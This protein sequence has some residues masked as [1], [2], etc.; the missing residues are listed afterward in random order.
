[1]IDR[2]PNT[3]IVNKEQSPKKKS[4]NELTQAAIDRTF[5]NAAR[6]SNYV[7]AWENFRYMIL[8]G[9][10]TG[11]FGVIDM[12][13]DAG[14]QLRVTNLERTLIDIVVRPGYSGGASHIVKAY[15]RARKVVSTEKILRTLQQ[16]DYTY[17]YHQAIGFAMERAGF[18]NQ[19]LDPLRDEGIDYDFYLDYGIKDKEYDD[20]WRLIFP[21]GL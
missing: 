11:D 16:L 21:K 6:Q 20:A 9:K 3:I 1:L 10:Q 12:E 13:I 5:K 15:R 4:S 7:W 19:K 18:E 8:N 2:L 17:P 14:E